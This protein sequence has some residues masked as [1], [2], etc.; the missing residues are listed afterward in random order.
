[1]NR[2]E[3]DLHKRLL[4]TR[5]EAEREIASLSFRKLG[6]S[7]SPRALKQQLLGSGNLRLSRLTGVPATLFAYLEKHP[8]LS[9]T[10]GKLLL[11]SSKTRSKLLKPL[12][13]AATSWYVYHKFGKGKGK[14]PAAPGPSTSP[15]PS[16]EY[17]PG[18]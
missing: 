2:K 18:F 13:L 1:M 15:D 10:V 8:R 4:M 5:I 17:P 12:V 11:S 16:T 14:G 3:R 6:L 9:L 7:A